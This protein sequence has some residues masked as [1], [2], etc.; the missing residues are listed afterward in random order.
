ME[1]EFIYWRHNTPP[2]I[3]VEEISGGEDKSGKVWM[4]LAKQ[5]YSEN[6]RDGYRV[7]D[8]TP[9]GVP[10]LEDE[11]VRISVSHAGHLLVVASLPRTPEADLASFSKRTA[12][13]IDTEERTRAQVLKIRDRFL[14]E[15]ELKIVPAESIEANILAWTAKEALYKASLIEG[16]DFR[17]CIKISEFPDPEAQTL[18]H[19]GVITPNGEEI[20]YIL[21]SYF[22]DNN[23]VTIAY[24]PSTATFKKS[25]K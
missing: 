23:I 8:H 21:Y 22:S 25:R 3:K 16:L 2:G 13:G 15:E 14:S 17:C 10:L 7:I 1:T 5:V 11:D 9:S 18:G 6:G 19:A 12:L 20:E 4:A 24:T